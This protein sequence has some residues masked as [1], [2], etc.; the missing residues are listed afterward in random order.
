MTTSS[1]LDIGRLVQKFVELRDD[2]DRIDAE[3]KKKK[4]PVAAAMLMIS[5]ALMKLA[6]D[7]GVASFKT[8]AGTAFIKTS[9]RCGVSNFEETLAHCQAT[10]DFHLLTKGVSKTAVEE[11]ITKNER[12]PPGVKYETFKEIQ[13]RRS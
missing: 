10:G 12:P 11:F 7:Q 1:Q 2:L 5:G 6:N 4:E 3:A 9:S 13:V 8:S